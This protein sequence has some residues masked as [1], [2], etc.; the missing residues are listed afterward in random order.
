MSVRARDVD[1]H[2][3]AH[4]GRVGDRRDRALVG[5]EHLEAHPR[6]AS[7]SAPRASAAAGRPPSGSAPGCRRRS[8]GSARAPS[9]CR[10]STPPAS[11][12]SA[13]S[14]TSSAIRS[15]P[16]TR[17]RSFA[18]CGPARSIDTSLI[19]SASTTAAVGAGRAHPERV[20]HR[21]LGRR[22]PLD[23][24]AP[25]AK[26]SSGSRRCR[27]SS[28][29]PAARG[30]RFACSVESISPSPPSATM[31][32]A[33]STGCWPCRA[34]SRARASSASATGLATKWI[35]SIAKLSPPRAARRHSRPPP[36]ANSSPVLPAGD[37]GFPA[38]AVRA[39]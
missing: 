36:P 7:G 39:N 2:R 11:T 37:S 21:R 8:A 27:G 20:D 25:R 28:R 26:R 34:T 4:L 18:A 16:S 33:S 24:A 12:S 32:S 1:A 13:P 19:A 5:V 3:V 38:P 31:T 17:M 6:R 15:R 9:S 14:A 30:S 10:R 29:R 22:Q 35:R 23:A